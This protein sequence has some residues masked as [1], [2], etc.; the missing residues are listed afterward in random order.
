MTKTQVLSNKAAQTY[1]KSL[2]KGQWK[3]RTI[4][5][6]NRIYEVFIFNGKEVLEIVHY[7][8]RYKE[9]YKLV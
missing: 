3:I 6:V 9:V 4:E 2:G 1:L 5:F 7:Q 8:G